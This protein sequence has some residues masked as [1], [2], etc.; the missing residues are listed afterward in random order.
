MI[1]YNIQRLMKIMKSLFILIFILICNVFLH[2]NTLYSQPLSIVEESPFEKIKVGIQYTNNFNRNELH[3][4]WQPSG[5]I[6]GF[7]ETQFY[8]GRMQL[9]LR[10]MNFKS[11]NS[12]IPDFFSWFIYGGW[13]ME[14]R[15]FNVVQLY[16]GLNIGS[17][18]MNFNDE[19]IEPGLKNE[20]ELGLE[21]LLKLSFLILKNVNLN[22]EGC[23][24]RIFTNKQLN[25]FYASA[26]F[27]YSFNSPVWLIDFL[28]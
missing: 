16:G 18:Q 22:I 8:F 17:F 2:N 27:D 3:N 5:G 4:T 11:K 23:Y 9:G 6:K 14:I 24:L 12:S 28:N 15:T 13:G 19:E 1:D 10:L 26:G 7:F 25:L 21:F 20:S